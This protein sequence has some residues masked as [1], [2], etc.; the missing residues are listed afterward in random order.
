MRGYLRALPCPVINR[1]RPELWYKP[2]LSIPDLVS[3]LPA[4]RFKVPKTL[5]A[6]SFEDAQVFFENCGH[7]IC[8][9][10]LTI[11]SRYP[12]ETGEELQKLA[13]LSGLL[14]FHLRE[15]VPGQAGSAYVVGADVVWE[16]LS[17]VPMPEAAIQEHCVEIAASLGLTFC[18]LQLLRSYRH[19]WYCLGI[20]C[21][22]DLFQCAEDTQRYISERLTNALLTA[23]TAAL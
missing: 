9:S 5:V 7:R 4:L 19:E 11:P 6:T 21:M 3:F 16:S 20:A 8:Y 17:G 23:K 14:P 2:F 22:P 13:T 1:V 10:P 12:I 15:V 18:E